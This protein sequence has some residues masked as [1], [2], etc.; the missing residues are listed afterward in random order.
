MNINLKLILAIVY[1]FCLG[2]IFLIVFSY[3]DLKDL[4]NYTFIRNSASALI[5]YK[6]SNFILFLI[7]FF[8]FSV[9]WIFFL[10]F[11]SP[12]AILSGFIFGQ[13]IGTLITVVSFTLGS[14]L[15]YLLASFY[16]TEIITKHL[17]SRIEKYTNLFQK[18]EL[19]YFMI[20]RFTGGGGIPFG[21]QNI[22]P[23]IFKMKLKNYIYSTF[24]GLMPVI[25]I[26]NTLGSG[27]ENIINKNEQLNYKSIILD[28]EI[29]I[30]IISFIIILFVSFFLRKKFFKDK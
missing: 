1:A 8:F 5:D 15:L 11:G 3:L 4:T 6:N 16:F 7:L 10:G 2:G 12:I 14:S 28:P 23:V 24:F 19:I 18:N 27:L 29:Y 22:L 26:I 25:F 13:W 17:S 9:M 30:P 21:I 20:F